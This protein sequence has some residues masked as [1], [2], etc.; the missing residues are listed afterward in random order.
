MKEQVLQIDPKDNVLVALSD[1][2][3]QGTVS[4][5]G[6]SYVLRD[7]IPAKHKFFTTDMKAGEEVIMYGTLVGKVQADLPSG[8]LMTTGNTKHAAKDYGYRASNFQ[9]KKPDISRFK[10]RFFNG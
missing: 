1:L 10:D 4:F 8:T 7:D 2:K 6:N 5:N 9:W 3:N